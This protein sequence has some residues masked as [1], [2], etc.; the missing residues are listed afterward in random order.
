MIYRLLNACNLLHESHSDL[1]VIQII[2]DTF[3]VIDRKNNAVSHNNVTSSIKL[4]MNPEQE[5]SCSCV[6]QYQYTHIDIKFVKWYQPQIFQRAAHNKCA[7]TYR[8]KNSV[9]IF[10]TLNLG[11][12]LHQGLHQEIKTV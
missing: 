2:P 6:I 11:E 8:T 5:D 4:S 1:L 10:A 7:N 9:R 12:L 3:Y